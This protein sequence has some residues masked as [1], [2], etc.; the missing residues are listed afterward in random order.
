MYGDLLPI[1]RFSKMTRLSV[2]ALRLYDQIGLL[3][4][5][6]VDEASG[7]RYYRLGQATQAE[8]IRALRS[9][10]MPLEE[11]RRVLTGTHAVMHD[12][13]AAHRRRL[14]AE[15]ERHRRMLTF[16]EDLLNGKAQL[17]PYDIEV[18]KI[19]D[20]RVAA[21]RRRTSLATI[22]EA[23][24]S[25]GEELM[26]QLAPRGITP[27]GPFFVLYHDVIDDRTE[28]DIEV[29]VPLAE[30]QQVDTTG[31]VYLTRIPGG[32]AAATL[33][34]GSYDQIRPAYHALTAW[35]AGEGRELV[36]SPR[37]VYLNTP[38]DTAPDDLRTEIVWPLG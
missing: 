21:A 5:A 38:M 34:K 13:L 4:P 25:A 15:V 33:H 24:G 2:K 28:G 30:D 9:L 20:Q 29:C 11:I 12:T 19:P 14:A 16:T 27:A 35:A 32:E 31:E 7:Y 3:S 17:M 8:A 10:D 26:G 6:H 23:I 36:G 22:S 18:K 37:E 1:G